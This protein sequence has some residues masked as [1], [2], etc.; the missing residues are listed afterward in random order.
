MTLSKIFFIP[1]IL[2]SAC[3]FLPEILFADDSVQKIPKE[4][5]Q[6]TLP[7]FALCMDVHDDK[8]RT[9]EQQN[10]MLRELGFDGV[11]HLWLKG[12]PERVDS[13]KK[14]SLKITQ[15]YFRVDLSANPPFDQD[16]SHVLPCLKGQGSQLALLIYGGKPSD[17]LRDEKTVEIITQI[18]RIAEQSE[19]QVV[20]YPHV[21][22]WL[23]KVSD[24]VRIAKKCNEQY[25]DRK[26]GVMFNLCHWAAVDKSENLEQ[27][28]TLAK[29]YLAS[30]TINGTDSPEEIQFQ[31]G[32]WLQPLDSGS[33]NIATLLGLLKK[34]DYQGPV[35]LQCYGIGGDAKE[36][37]TRSMKA[38]RLLNDL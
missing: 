27:V 26:I 22:A 25:P 23:E 20:L 5:L 14:Y 28:L 33:F 18:N 36:H 34:I 31:K 3:L 35:G 29:P 21:G 38:W 9:I 16:L 10:E 30:V 8:R 37:L 1:I 15:V 6:K 11:A 13:A 19:V 7:F 32:N 4:T 24:A 17:T 2:L 12:L